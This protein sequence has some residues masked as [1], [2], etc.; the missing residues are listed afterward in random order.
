VPR[1]G[2]AVVFE[3]EDTSEVS[4]PA[5]LRLGAAET[6]R[7]SPAS[8]EADLSMP[9]RPAPGYKPRSQRAPENAPTVPANPADKDGPLALASPSV[10]PRPSDVRPSWG[11]GPARPADH[12]D[13]TVPLPRKPLPRNQPAWVV[14]VFLLL[15]S[16]IAVLVYLIWRTYRAKLGS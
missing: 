6:E 15:G 16:V 14:P 4:S 9:D 11:T 3:Q 10:K 7:S 12:Q 5:R 1:S 13:A 2:D 8:G